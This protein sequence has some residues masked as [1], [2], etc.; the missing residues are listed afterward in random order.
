[1]ASKILDDFV[2]NLNSGDINGY[3]DK[4]QARKDRYHKLGRR[5][6]TE[7][8]NDMGYA[9]TEFKITV[10]KAGPAGPGDVYMVA[11]GLEIH[12]WAEGMGQG[13]EVLFRSRDGNRIGGN[14]WT[15]YDHL[16][17]RWEDTLERIKRVGGNG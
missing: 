3:T 10:N 7:M 17:S 4:N 6:L 5:L 15:T 1:M 14:N 9:S 12:L 2:Q 8:A 11:K 13:L 16:F